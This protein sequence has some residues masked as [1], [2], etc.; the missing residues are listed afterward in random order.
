MKGSTTL[1]SV[2]ALLTDRNKLPYFLQGNDCIQNGYETEIEILQ[3]MWEAGTKGVLH[4]NWASGNHEGF[5]IF[6]FD[7]PSIVSQKGLDIGEKVSGLHYIESDKDYITC[8]QLYFGPDTYT[9][10]SCYRGQGGLLIKAM[11]KAMNHFAPKTWWREKETGNIGVGDKYFF[12]WISDGFGTKLASYSLEIS[13][14][15][16]RVHPETIKNAHT[17]DFKDSTDSISG[18]EDLVPGTTL[19]EFFKYIYDNIDSMY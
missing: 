3:E 13:I 10:V 6:A 16:A 15:Q 9:L 8:P 7:K 18:F 17:A 1:D 19:N 2:K 11:M 5:S 4:P 14:F 12:S